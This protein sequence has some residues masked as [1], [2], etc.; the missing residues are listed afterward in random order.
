M[1]I[2]E[3][4][5]PFILLPPE[6]CLPL[7]L[8]NAISLGV[9]LFTTLRSD[10]PHCW[11]HAHLKRLHHQ[12]IQ[13]GW[14]L[15]AFREFVGWLTPTLAEAFNT[16]GVWRITLVPHLQGPGHF[17]QGGDVIPPQVTCLLSVRGDL[18]P[19]PPK[20]PQPQGTLHV[21]P[22]HHPEPMYKHASQWGS[23]RLRQQVAPRPFNRMHPCQLVYVS[24]RRRMATSPR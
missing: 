10:T 24:R 15:P 23:L 20:L 16:T 11:Q 12:A 8:F 4:S 3:I 7:H 1:Y 19:I 5:K 14:S 17:Y 9:S 13:A 18:I 2:A 21:Q 22:Y 6:G